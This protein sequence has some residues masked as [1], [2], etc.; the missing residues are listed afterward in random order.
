MVLSMGLFA[1]TRA[2]M[3]GRKG[4]QCSWI[5][6]SSENYREHII[7]LFI[8][9]KTGTELLGNSLKV[10]RKPITGSRSPTHTQMPGWASFR[11]IVGQL[12]FSSLLDSLRIIMVLK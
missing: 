3:W 1:H 10:Q 5:S 9:V 12:A 4:V 7:T 11:G 6:R 8:H 2:E